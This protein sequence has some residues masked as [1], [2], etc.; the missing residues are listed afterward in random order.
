MRLDIAGFARASRTDSHELMLGLCEKID[1]LGFDGIWFNEFHFQ[2]P[3]QAYPSTLML[4]S[5]IFARTRRLRVGTS[6]VVTPLYHP[7]LL[8]EEVAQLHWQSAGRFDLG[9]GRGTHPATLN[10]LGI[11][12][13]T[14]RDRFEQSYRIMSEAWSTG[15]IINGGSCWPASDIPVGPLLG[16]ESVPVYVA[17]TSRDTLGFA[18]R[19]GLPLLLSLDPPEAA[20]IA[21]YRGIIE[22]EGHGCR[23]QASSLSRYVCIARTTALAMAKLDELIPRLHERRLKS[24]RAAGRPTDQILLPDRQT[25]MS[26]QIIAGSPEDCVAQLNALAESTGIEAVRLVFNGN[27]ILDMQAAIAD[28]EL[29]AGEVL[30]VLVRRP[31]ATA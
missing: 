6:I 7:Y 8:A 22:E 29:F 12:A 17:G 1:R 21:T 23:L 11:A 24:A 19:E 18:A 15:A 27:G 2:N 25:A 28:M 30:P 3:P 31:V 20:Q 16:D 4:A 14:T 10:S 5:A 13:E 9:I 26:R